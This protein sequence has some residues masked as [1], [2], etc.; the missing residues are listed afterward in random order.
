M[1]AFPLS[2]EILQEELR[3][4]ELTDE[5]VLHP[6]THTATRSPEILGGTLTIELIN[7]YTITPQ[8]G[9][10]VAEFQD[11]NMIGDINFSAGVQV[12]R[13]LSVAFSAVSG[14]TASEREAL[15]FI[16]DISDGDQRREADRLRIWR[17]GVDKDTTEPILDKRVTGGSISAPPIELVDQ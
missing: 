15:E 10:Y 5:G 11:G 8:E 9:S 1:D 16:R 4:I 7:N 12:V 3:D 13:P 14:L 17:R 6:P 2:V